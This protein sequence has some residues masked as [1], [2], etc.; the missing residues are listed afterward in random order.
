[1]VRRY[2]DFHWLHERLCATL[3]SVILPLFPGKKSIGKM[4]NAFV[5]QR[6]ADLESYMAQLI[7]HPRVVNSFDLVVFLTNTTKGLKAAMEYV[8]LMASEESEGDSVLSQ[9]MHGGG[10]PLVIQADEEFVNQRAFH[11]AALARL[12]ATTAVSDRL[13]TASHASADHLVQLG[14]SQLAVSE[15]E[16][17]GESAGAG[18]EAARDADNKAAQA[19]RDLSL[20]GQGGQGGDGG[21]GGGAAGSQA[22]VSRDAEARSAFMGHMHAR[23]ESEKQNEIDSMFSDDFDDPLAHAHHSASP[24]KRERTP[25]NAAAGDESP[26]ATLQNLFRSVGSEALRA[27]HMRCVGDVCVCLNGQ[28]VLVDEC[29]LFFLPLFCCCR[30]AGM[31]TLTAWSRFCTSQCGWNSAG[32]RRSR[33][34]PTVG[35]RQ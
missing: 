3:P 27:G 18:A 26:T 21:E 9:L 5:Q 20:G 2:S 33:R 29:S 12:Q 16:R 25:S 34:R 14:N 22:I 28:C 19:I 24:S 11:S 15:A 8:R 7:R 35:N 23:V 13:S 10:Q 32:R 6:M 31:I 1:M 30:E 17:R 4:D